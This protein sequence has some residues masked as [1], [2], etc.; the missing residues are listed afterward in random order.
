MKK[1]FLVLTTSM[2][3]GMVAQISAMDEFDP[4][5]T[6]PVVGCYSSQNLR[7]EPIDS[8]EYIVLSS[9]KRSYSSTEELSDY[10]RKCCGLPDVGPATPPPPSPTKKDK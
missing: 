4:K 5:K 2:V 10:A 9:I 1:S 6:G 7:F 3:L 8:I